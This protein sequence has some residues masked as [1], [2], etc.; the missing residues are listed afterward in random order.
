W[1]LKALFPF[2]IAKN[3]QQLEVIAIDK[4]G[5]EEIVSES[6][7]ESDQQEI[8]FAFN[9]LFYLELCCLPYLTYFYP[10]MHKTT[11]TA[12]KQLRIFRC[13]RIKI[14][15]HEE[16]QI[17]HPLFLIEKVRTATLFFLLAK[18]INCI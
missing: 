16:S 3:L 17:Q 2:S 15:G 18:F 9:K 13:G 10:R 6:V 11:W 1:S 12:L 7:E 5:L 8:R 14:F 4:C